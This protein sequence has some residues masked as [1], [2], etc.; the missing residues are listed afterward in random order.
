V[1]GAWHAAGQVWPAFV[2]VG[3]LLLVGVVAEQDGLFAAAGTA[4]ARTRGGTRTAYVLSL[5]LVV[6]VTAVLNLDTSVFFLTPVLLHLARARGVDEAPFLYGSVF[7]SN[8]ASLFL[9]GSNLT[10]LIVLHGDHV[11]GATFLSRML[12]AAVAAVLST[13]LLLVVVFRRELGSPASTSFERAPLRFGV[14]VAAVALSTIAV[15]V[16]AAPAVPVLAIGTAAV[17]LGRVDR[18]RVAAVL[19]LR[20]LVGLFMLAVLLG[21]VGRW[22]NGPA[23]LLDQLGRGGTAVAGAVAA[24]TLNN[25]PASVLLTPHPPEHARALL[26]GLNLGPNLA[27]TGSL[28]A[29][30]WLRVA[31]ALGAQPSVRRY[32]RLGIA[33]VPALAGRRA[34]DVVALD[35]GTAREARVAV[36]QQPEVGVGL[37]LVAQHPGA[38]V[39]HPLVHASRR[40][41]VEPAEERDELVD[42]AKDIRQDERR[43]G[44]HEAEEHGEPGL[45]LR[46]FDAQVDGI[47]PRRA[48]ER[49]PRVGEQ[50]NVGVRVRRGAHVTGQE[51]VQAVRD[52]AGDEGDEPRE[53]L[54]ERDH[55]AP[56][57]KPDELRK[58]EQDPEEHR[59]TGAAE[60]V[61][62][63]EA[64]RV[65][66]HGAVGLLS[67]WTPLA[68]VG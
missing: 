37:H 39:A 66:G 25:L 3:G 29:F 40:E 23:S 42:D 12:P 36:G 17:V 67:I 35:R 47:A 2:L 46:R 18:A 5:A 57:A 26:L 21:A 49:R 8:A 13:A 64:D 10:N 56:Q 15:L 53:E 63:D 28:S 30:L 44:E 27:V 22:W 24:I 43:D 65:V 19:D 9:P 33:L 59:H 1:N 52:P 20:V 50:E 14:G 58:R 62:D 45:G 60:V 61:V 68:S 6:C 4:L 54:G 16:L 7:M 55:D 51:V 34:R 32:S 41:A 38:Q 31:R 48:R 11:S